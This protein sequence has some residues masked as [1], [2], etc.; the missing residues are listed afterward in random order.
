MT[1]PSDWPNPVTTR[2]Q[3]MLAIALD[4][5]AGEDVA[6]RQAKVQL[7]EQGRGGWNLTLFGSGSFDGVDAVVKREVDLAIINPANGLMMAHRGIGPYTAPQPVCQISVIPSFD[8]FL[9]TVRPEVGITALEDIPKKKPKLVFALRGQREHCMNIML[10]DVF[11]AAGFSFEDIARW[12]G[13][14]RYEGV[15][16]WADT[17]KFRDAVEGRTNALIDEGAD[18]WG[19]QA[20][21]AGMVTLTMAEETVRNLEARGYRRGILKRSLF[22]K[23]STDALSIDFS[24]WPIVCRPDLEESKVRRICASLEANAHLIKWQGEGPLP[25]TRMC[26]EADDTPQMVPYH[27]AAAAYWRERGYLGENRQSSA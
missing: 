5:V 13:E 11:A 3:V 26:R 15:L 19:N 2:S 9:L 25:V 17:P 4:L 24:G 18:A 1:Q 8:Q 16:P 23:L 14:V 21:D 12:G 20:M 22:P 7:K 6:L 27:S 10:K